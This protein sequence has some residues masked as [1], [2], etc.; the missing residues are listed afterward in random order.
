METV[1]AVQLHPDTVQLETQSSEWSF[2]RRTV[3]RFCFVY[4]GVYSLSTQIITG[5][6]PVPNFDIP[7][8][9][10]FRP[11]RPLVFWTAAHIFRV[12]QPLV[13]TGSGSGDKT[14]DWVLLFCT[15]VFS[16][17]ATA[18]WSALDRERPNYVTL[19]KWFRVFI[20]LCLAGQ[21]MVYGMAKAVPL[22]MPFPYLTRL[23]ERYGDL[24]PMGVLWSSIGA[25]PSYEIFAGCAELLGGILLIFPRTTTL[26]ALVCLADMTQVFML[27]MTYDVPVK[28]LSFHLILLSLFLL[29]PD[30]K[31]LANFF[32][33]N[34]AAKPQAHPALF[35]GRRANRIALGAQIMVG[36]WLLGMNAY[37]ARV[38]WQQ[39]GG[40]RTVSALYGIWDVEQQSV[41]GQQ[42][43]PLMNDSGRWRRAI[44]DFPTRVT[45]QRIDD[46][47]AHHDVTIDLKNRTMVISDDQDK[48]WKANFRFDRPTADQLTLDGSMD[49]H[50]THL[51]L[52]LVDRSKLELVSRG[53]HWIQEYPYNR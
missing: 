9:S 31:R 26:G 21:M 22:Q 44:F 19:D 15:L 33:L 16:L 25:S 43:A 45:F 39:Y 30:F 46:S 36:A 52:K 40:G 53:F 47:F 24:S 14:F 29:V 38:G 20:R 6:V 23:L 18:V 4:F 17:I 49:G 12:R 34:R 10:T 13:Y 1:Q 50:N 42:R 48:N 2:A 7:D 37:S 8:P 51:Q 5:F 35:A 41:D 3:F 32:L 11:I 27:N 28:L